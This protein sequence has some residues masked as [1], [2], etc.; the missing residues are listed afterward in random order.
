[1]RLNLTKD[2]SDLMEYKGWPL[3]K[4]VKYEINDKLVK[5]GGKDSGGLIALDRQGNIATAFNTTG[6][7]RGWID[8]RGRVV[9][10]IFKGE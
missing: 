9:V 3:L 8:T 2:V 1:M 5:F 7:Y 10:K 6:M 4:A